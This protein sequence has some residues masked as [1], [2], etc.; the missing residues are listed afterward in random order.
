MGVILTVCHLWI[1]G[2]WVVML[3]YWAVAA[4][5]TKRTVDRG[6]G[7]GG[8]LVRLGLA[9]A[10][11]LSVM[12]A[13]RSHALQ[14]FQTAEL[15][16]VAM[17]LAGALVATAGAA[18]A[19]TA[20][21][22]IGRNWGTPGSRKADT[23]LV[24]SGPYQYVRHPIYSGV[25]LMMAGTAIGLIPT[26]WLVFAAAAAYFLYSARLEEGLMTER[27]PDAYPAYKE[28][29]KMLLPFIL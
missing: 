19:F 23:D 7:G 22:V 26:W 13:R 17:A 27:F 24:T 28:R 18:L 4:F 8:L 10:V 9:C 25:L 1:A 16:S 14:A 11:V 29:T 5:F 15:R 3:A 20:R 6:L 21:A 2:L 12:L